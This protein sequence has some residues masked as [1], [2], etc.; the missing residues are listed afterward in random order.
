MKRLLNDSA[1]LLRRP[2]ESK[3]QSGPNC[4]NTS[5]TGTVST[6]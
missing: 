2:V 6:H 5:S 3:Q 4:D 1:N